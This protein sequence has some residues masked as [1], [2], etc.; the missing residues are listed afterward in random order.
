MT[1]SSLDVRALSHRAVVRLALHIERVDVLGLQD[2]FLLELP[3]GQR[4]VDSADGRR[5]ARELK[6]VEDGTLARFLLL[7]VGSGRLV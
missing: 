5:G 2:D 6:S 3:H 4:E 1:D 7:F